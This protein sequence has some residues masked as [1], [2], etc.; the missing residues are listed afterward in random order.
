LQD[1]AQEEGFFFQMV[2]AVILEVHTM[3]L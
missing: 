3:Y 1:I 2:V